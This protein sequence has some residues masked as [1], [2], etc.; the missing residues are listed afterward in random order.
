MPTAG[1]RL[2]GPEDYQHNQQ[3][4]EKL[5][6]VNRR[7]ARTQDQREQRLEPTQVPIAA[8]TRLQMLALLDQTLAI[9]LD[10]KTLLGQVH[11]QDQGMNFEP[12][13][14]ELEAYVGLFS[15][16][17]RTLD[18]EAKETGPAG[19]TA[20]SGE[21]PDFWHIKGQVMALAE[22]LVPYAKSLR[23]RSNC[24]EVSLGHLTAPAVAAGDGK[25]A[26]MGKT[27]K[28]KSQ[29]RRAISKG[30]IRS[31]NTQGSSEQLYYLPASGPRQPPAC[32]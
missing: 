28:R 4:E 31:Q 15:A 6:R 14:N 5:M 12:L 22:H 25:A 19:L 23:C 17:M 32:T 9:T 16:W 20:L 1:K 30:L 2:S 24:S 10:L 27:S 26:D 21:V 11:E 29:L 7:E 8:T 18:G 3:T 13:V